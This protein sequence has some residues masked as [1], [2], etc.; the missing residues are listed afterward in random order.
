MGVY[1]CGPLPR[2]DTFACVEC[3]FDV[4]LQQ[5]PPG[6]RRSLIRGVLQAGSNHFSI[7][8]ADD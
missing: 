5:L 7:G 3:T 6:Q 1:L 2:I 4:Q 8:V